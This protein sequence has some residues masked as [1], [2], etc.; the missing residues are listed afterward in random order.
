MATFR[1][2]QLIPFAKKYDRLKTPYESIRNPQW[3]VTRVMEIGDW[4]DVL[5]IEDLVGHEYMGEVL[6]NAE[7]GTFRTKSWHFLA[8]QTRPC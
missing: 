6:V 1:P 2:E 4:E 7:P 5:E 8:L 3:I